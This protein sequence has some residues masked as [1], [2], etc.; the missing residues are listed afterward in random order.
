[1]QVVVARKSF[2]VMNMMKKDK[3]LK[4]NKYR[5]FQYLAEMAGNNTAE[6]FVLH[7]TVA[8]DLGIHVDTV[9]RI[10]NSLVAEGYILKQMVKQ[11]YT[12]NNSANRYTICAMLDE[13]SLQI[14]R[15][16]VEL[17][18]VFK[19][20]VDKV[21]DM[22]KLAIEKLYD[23]EEEVVEE[24]IEEVAPIEEP[25]VEEPKFVPSFVPSFN[26]N[27]QDAEVE[28]ESA[29]EVVTEEPKLSFKDRLFAFIN[30]NDTTIAKSLMPIAEEYEIIIS[31][32]QMTEL[33]SAYGDGAVKRALDRTFATGNVHFNFVKSH[34]ENKYK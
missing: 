1:M 31:L 16:M 24:V 22:L 15:K 13:Q 30:N 20:G 7:S 10:T 28:E 8:G 32:E 3:G 23:K 29:E 9:R 19:K 12:N 18:P 17:F 11:K 14:K 2:E 5:V 27:N 26:L 34:L 33:V 25:A 21:E 6:C 4:G